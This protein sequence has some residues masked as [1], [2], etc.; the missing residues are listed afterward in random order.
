VVVWLESGRVRG[1]TRHS[2]LWRNPDYRAVFTQA[3]E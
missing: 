2:T 1:A 3:G